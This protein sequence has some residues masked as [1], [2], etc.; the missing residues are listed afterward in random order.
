MPLIS[1]KREIRKAATLETH[2]PLLDDDNR[3]LVCVGLGDEGMKLLSVL[4]RN[5]GRHVCLGLRGERGTESEP[6]QKLANRLKRFRRTSHSARGVC[7]SITVVYI[8]SSS[9]SGDG[10]F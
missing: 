1:K 6:S 7:L 5:L 2:V 8:F 3:G 4:A 9:L 10:Q